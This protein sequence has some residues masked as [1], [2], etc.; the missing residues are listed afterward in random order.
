MVHSLS[1]SEGGRLPLPNCPTVA[2]GRENPN[3]C[4]GSKPDESV[5]RFTRRRINPNYQTGEEDA[6]LFKV[7]LLRLRVN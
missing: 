2:L 6:P 5:I 7:S 1:H 3:R 4:V